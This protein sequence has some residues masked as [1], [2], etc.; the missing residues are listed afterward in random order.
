[1]G[2]VEYK[3]ESIHW[4]Q[5]GTHLEALV[6]HLNEW[7]KDGWRVASVDLTPGPSFEMRTLPV[8]LERDVK[9]A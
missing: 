4:E 7:A 3:V 5:Q 6:K 8:L 9:T 2:H 1:M